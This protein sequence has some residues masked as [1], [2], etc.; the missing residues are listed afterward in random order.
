M[1]ELRHYIEVE[2]TKV[3]LKETILD[4]SP[5]PKN[6]GLLK[7]KSEQVYV[8]EKEVPAEILGTDEHLQRLQNFTSF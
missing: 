6:P 2:S 1:T 4:V 5:D 7:L 3:Y 8:D